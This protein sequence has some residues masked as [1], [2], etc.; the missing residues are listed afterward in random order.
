MG[1][2]HHFPV[3]DLK[4]CCFPLSM[5]GMFNKKTPYIR[6]NVGRFVVTQVS[7]VCQHPTLWG[8]RVAV[9]RWTNWPLRLSAK[10][11]SA[12]RIGG[13]VYW[14]PGL[15]LFA[16]AF[17][18]S[19]VVRY[20]YSRRPGTSSFHAAKVLL[21]SDSTKLFWKKSTQKSTLRNGAETERVAG[22]GRTPLHRYICKNQLSATK[23][24][25]ICFILQNLLLH[26]VLVY[27]LL[28]GL[29]NRQVPIPAHFLLQC[30]EKQD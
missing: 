23:T 18:S 15:P 9:L 27:F 12:G 5:M 29:E 16:A 13:C 26:Q 3:F 14:L 20:R 17:A 7:Q 22:R 21:F 30:P 28:L 8:Y 4:K 2:R 10:G 24:S 19:G 11:L 1:S 6:W 25:E